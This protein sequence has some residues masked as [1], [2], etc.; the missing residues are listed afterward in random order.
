MN[1]DLYALYQSNADF[2]EYVDRWCKSRG[3]GIFEAFNFV[4][5]R[6]YAKWLKEA[7]K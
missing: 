7:K 2:H 6:E 3:N 5:V 4:I 1:D